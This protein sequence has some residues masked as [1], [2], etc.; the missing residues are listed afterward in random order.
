[1]ASPLIALIPA[2]IW[3][4]S[5]IYYR[6]FL[7]KFDFLSLNLVRTSLATAVLLVP[8]LYFGF[9]GSVTFAL[10]SG[11]ITFAIGDTLYLLAIRETGASVAAPVSYTYVLFVQ[12]TAFLV[13]EVVPLA[14]FGSAALVIV[15]VFLLSRGGRGKPRA[16]GI[17][18]AL[19]AGVAWTAGQD[20]IAVVT[21]SGMNVV[22]IAFVRFLAAAVALAIVVTATGRHRNWPKVTARD[23]GFIALIALADM[24]VGSLLF[25]YS[26][27]TVGVALTV[28]VVS[29]SPFATQLL[30][31]VMGREPP[32]NMDMVGGALIVAAL[33]LAVAL[34]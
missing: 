11:A 28:I 26:V 6:A 32:S 1:L 22:S 15:G 14:N 24:V 16:K 19:V 10:L 18:I 30:S 5:P 34:A 2:M 29:V 4:I 25:I 27:S 20:M 12:M 21:N 23:F 33:I 8:A 7:K 17:A 9:S 13:G 31:R 3:A